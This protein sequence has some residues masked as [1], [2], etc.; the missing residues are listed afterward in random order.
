M[1][2]P[3]PAAGRFVVA[4][5][6]IRHLTPPL[7]A[8]EALWLEATFRNLPPSLQSPSFALALHYHRVYPAPLLIAYHPTLG[9]LGALCYTVY[10]T[11]NR[12]LASPVLE[13][14]KLASTR[15]LPGTGTALMEAA[16]ALALKAGLHLSLLYESDALPFYTALGLRPTSHGS[17]RLLWRR[18]QMAKRLPSPPPLL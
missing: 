17:M 13:V 2:T 12:D 9:L 16:A 14:M 7:S 8:N 15:V 3:S 10:N 18:S 1:D 5:G 6:L 4:G 11:G